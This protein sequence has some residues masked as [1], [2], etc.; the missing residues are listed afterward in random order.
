MDKAKQ[1]LERNRFEASELIWNCSFFS[2]S[3]DLK[4]HGIDV[5]SPM[6]PALVFGRQG[7][8]SIFI[9]IWKMLATEFHVQGLEL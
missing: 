9:F 4:P 6:D 1:W 5:R 3:D 2:S 8:C 7:R